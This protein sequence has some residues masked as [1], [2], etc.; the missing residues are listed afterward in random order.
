VIDTRP[1]TFGLGRFR[2]K[3]R[4]NR[5]PESIGNKRFGHAKL[6]HSPRFC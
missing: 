2:W 3:E 4:L 6:T 1:A 5:R